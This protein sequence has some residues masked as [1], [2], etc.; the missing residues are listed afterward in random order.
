[1]SKSITIRRPQ[2]VEIPEVPTK[3]KRIRK[4]TDVAVADV[5]DAARMLR[6]IRGQ[7]DRVGAAFR[8]ALDRLTEAFQPTLSQ[9][10]T[11]D[12]HLSA[13][14]ENAVLPVGQAGV[15]QWDLGGFARVTFRKGVASVAVEDEAEAVRQLHELGH[16]DLIRVKETVDKTAVKR[17]GVPEGVDAIEITEPEITAKI[18]V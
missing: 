6:E 2:S 4:E 7:R 17:A 13:L 11:A 5:H 10:E 15:K 12:V 3:L 18:E 14:I 16:D 1:M 9:L 8:V